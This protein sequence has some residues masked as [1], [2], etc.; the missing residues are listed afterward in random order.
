MERNK[1]S[2]LDQFRD[3]QERKVAI[4]AEQTP[5][6]HD[7]EAVQAQINKHEEEV[8]AI[9]N[10]IEEL[11]G[12]RVKAQNEV[13]FYEKKLKDE[14]TKVDELDVIAKELQQEFEEWTAKA[15]QY[16]ERVENPRNPDE[17]ERAVKSTQKALQDREREAG[18]TVEDLQLALLRATTNYE[19]AQKDLKEM[20][21]L[22]NMLKRSLQQ[23][24]GRWYDFRRHI[25][26]RTKLQFTYHLSVRGYFGKVLFDHTNETLQLKVQTDDAAATQSMDKDP[27]SL[28]GGEKSFSTICL[29]LSLWEAIG[30][31]IRC[32]DEFDVFMDAVNRRISMKMM[33]ETANSSDSKQY[34]LITPQD[35]STVA[36]GPT[37]RVNRMPDPERG[38]TTLPL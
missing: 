32:L 18:A 28:S 16:C 37:V 35:M 6:M 29:L 27:R 19:T 26:L 10:E 11:A 5:L 2:I 24:L 17:V 25:A 8:Q 21:Q 13:K 30:C 7:K 38:Q 36:L 31:P 14:Q 20:V 1:A 4:N 9:K 12:P 22:N 3:L 23:R 34:I 15:E 33:I